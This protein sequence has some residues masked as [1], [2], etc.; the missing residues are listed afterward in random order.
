M[1]HAK[2]CVRCRDGISEPHTL[3]N[4]ID[5]RQFKCVQYLITKEDAINCVDAHGKTV[6]CAAALT[7]QAGLVQFLIEDCG[8]DFEKASTVGWNPMYVAAL[9]NHLAIV[10][11]LVE[12]G[13]CYDRRNGHGATP[14]YAAS[15]MDHMGVVEYLVG[16][17]ASLDTA[18]QDGCTPLWV[19]ASSGNLRVVKF[20]V[21]HGADYWK[22]N[23]DGVTPRKIA[24]QNSQKEVVE[25]LTGLPRKPEPK[26]RRFPWL[27]R[28]KKP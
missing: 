5:Q 20:L 23:A 21:E 17:G 14:L 3:W 13:A 12:R 16:V 4:A 18:D 19:A 11:Y 2:N 22:A 28:R 15:Q 26:S 27:P 24:K 9:N 8:A 7:G 10:R 1:E 25:F 6:V